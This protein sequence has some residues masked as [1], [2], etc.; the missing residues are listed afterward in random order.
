[1]YLSN[2]FCI[3]CITGSSTD[4]VPSLLS[5]YDTLLAERL[6]VDGQF[7]QSL[8][9][10]CAS[11]ISSTRFN[12]S[13]NATS[14]KSTSEGRGWGSEKLETKNGLQ[15]ATSGSNSKLKGLSLTTGSA[16]TMDGGGH[17]RTGKR[18]DFHSP[19][20]VTTLFHSGMELGGGASVPNN[21]SNN[22]ASDSVNSNKTVVGGT[23]GPLLT[24]ALWTTTNLINQQ[25]YNN[26]PTINRNLVGTQNSVSS[27]SM[28]HGKENQKRPLSVSGS[29]SLVSSASSSSCSSDSSSLG[30][31][32]EIPTSTAPFASPEEEILSPDLE[33]VSSSNGNEG[34][35][36]NDRCFSN[37]A[38]KG[39]NQF[40]FTE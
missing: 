9:A 12:T 39:E 23:G 31:V 18:C 20:S 37:S 7:A 4:L 21:K 40:C 19:G 2:I 14:I 17:S 30:I 10:T 15:S 36:E 5:I 33:M 26:A 8:T 38:N 29:S 3:L 16:S 1:M 11:N 34:A 25:K 27:G 32:P 28:L 6:S 35:I 24:R 22:N 13:T